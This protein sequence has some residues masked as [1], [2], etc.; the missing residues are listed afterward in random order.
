MG[1]QFVEPVQPLV[2]LANG[3]GGGTGTGATTAAVAATTA[4]VAA[5][6]T[7]VAVA[8]CSKV[9]R[10]GIDQEHRFQVGHGV[11]LVG[12][13]GEPAAVGHQEAAAGVLHAIDELVGLPPPVEADQHRPDVDGAPKGEAPFGVV[14][15]QHGQPVAVAQPEL[16]DQRVGHGV[17]QR[18]EGGKS[19]T[20]IAV[21]DELLGVPPCLSDGSDV[22]QRRHP[23]LVDLHRDPTDLLG[24][25]L[26]HPAWSRQQGLDFRARRHAVQPNWATTWSM[27]AVNA[28]T[29]CGS[30]AGNIPIR[31]WF[32]P[33][34]R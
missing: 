18:H 12:D 26:E 29:S 30:T 20:T 1:Q 2:G 24:G 28:L 32:R 15:R 3:T 11:E 22:T 23:V 27:Q 25:D 19:V 9:G 31:N 17:G 14:G 4:A 33:S 21:H 7:A 5:T 6:P 13:P 34:L 8:G 10:I 16:R